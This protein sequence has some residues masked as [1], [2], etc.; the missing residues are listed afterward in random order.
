ME[1]A[2][3]GKRTKLK[4]VPPVSVDQINL[5]RCLVEEP[6]LTLTELCE[7][8]TYSK[9]VN[10]ERAVWGLIKRGFIK[11]QKALPDSEMCYFITDDGR[12]L[13]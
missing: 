10:V 5:L 11:W 1:L 9:P 7:R 2:P 13:I 8:S 3:H 6:G 12:K 4:K